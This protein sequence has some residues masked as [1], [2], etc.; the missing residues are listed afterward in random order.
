[1]IDTINLSEEE[2]NKNNKQNDKK[3]ALSELTSLSKNELA[4]NFNAIIDQKNI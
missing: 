4:K 1:M 2:N 3:L